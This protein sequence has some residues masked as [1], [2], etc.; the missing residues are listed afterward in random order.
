MLPCQ[1]LASACA[2]ELGERLRHLA[3]EVERLQS[4]G[5]E[6]RDSPEEGERRGR[7]GCVA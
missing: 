6:Y 3:A 4:E 7:G 5:F 1:I 2:Q